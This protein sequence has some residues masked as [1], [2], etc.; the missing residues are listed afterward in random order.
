[1]FTG[2]LYKRKT[3]SS[4]ILGYEIHSFLGK[5]EPVKYVPTLSPIVGATLAVALNT[6][7]N[8]ATGAMTA[9]RATARIAPILY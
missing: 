2:S 9:N 7:M 6:G 5:T 8:I 1:L 3:V 4:L